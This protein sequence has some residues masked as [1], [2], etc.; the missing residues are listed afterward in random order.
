MIKNPLVILL[1]LAL[2]FIAF[3]YGKVLLSPN[4][5]LFDGRGDAL[6]NYYTFAY[7]IKNNSDLTEF[8]GMNYPYGENFM[9]TD[10]HPIQTAG[11]K[12]V[13]QIFP[14]S[15]NYSIGIL[16]LMML[17][18]FLLT[19][20]FI[21][22]IFVHLKI[23]KV[24]AIIGALGIMALS[25]QV[26]RFIGHWA[27]SY[28]FALPMVIYILLLLEEKYTFKRL[29]FMAL[30]ILF[31]FFTHAYLGI[32]AALLV[33]TFSGLALGFRLLKKDKV[34]LL[35]YLKIG[36]SAILPIMF[37]YAFVKLTDTHQNRTTNPW[38]V[39]EHHA[40]MRTVFLPTHGPLNP[41][42]EQWFG[43]KS[44]DQTWEGRA[45]LGIVG[46][47]SLPVFL[48]MFGF[49]FKREDKKGTLNVLGLLLLAAVLIFLFS[50]FLPF[51]ELWFK[52]VEKLAVVKQF[53]AI[54]RFAWV[55]FFVANLVGVYLVNQAFLWLKSKEKIGMAY[56]ILIALPFLVFFEGV[57]Y[58]LEAKQK[59]TAFKNGFDINQTEAN[60][61]SACG[62]INPKNYQAIIG[63]PYFYIG[64]DNFGKDGESDIY[65]WSFLFSY[66]LN[67][68]MFNSYLTRTSICESKN[69]MQLMSSEFIEKTIKNDLKSDL[70]FLVIRSN[71][72][73]N[74][75][76]ERLLAKSTKILANS[77]FALYEISPDHWFET[78]SELIHQKYL[79]EKDSLFNVNGF[80]VTDTTLFFQYE[81][82]K[83]WETQ[84]YVGPQ[85]N[86]N[87]L[88]TVDGRLLK[89]TETYVCRFW[90][91]NAGENCGQ[92]Q[93]NGLAYINEDLNGQ[94]TWLNSTV[95][96]SSFEIQ[97]DWTMVELSLSNINPQA[98]YSVVVLGGERS[99]ELY[100]IDHLL[101][102]NKAL[103]VFKEEE[104]E[105]F[106]NGYFINVAP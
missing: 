19:A 9:Y 21:Y 36:L 52:L 93:F 61:K 24:L 67:L 68:P 57:P 94:D 44:E 51:R 76:E 26:F 39:Y 34:G 101:F 63:L 89:P 65:K 86:Y 7:Y 90:V 91:R 37:F 70:P 81:D 2:S 73:L 16:N 15:A 17:G 46:M 83:D 41:I 55:L 30:S 11:L 102:Y 5:Y 42:K 54:G 99:K 62:K 66:H 20:L 1:V 35:K 23:N 97:G 69:S 80:K 60:F 58:H 72:A 74:Q 103:E 104:S 32:I 84:E 96:Q 87:T 28:S 92:D 29:V 50:A 4:S 71:E 3:F 56:A 48:I 53:R 31:L 43:V 98:E 79:G 33:F 6:K 12:L 38:G 47:V 78:N 106:Y 13:Y 95:I 105:L 18:S 22:L 14:Q 88:Y 8:Q 75:N 64:S 59:V 77:D 45:Y 27:L 85:N 40:E 49:Q 25:P 100:T 82:F 10:C